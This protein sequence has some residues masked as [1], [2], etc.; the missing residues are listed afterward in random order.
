MSYKIKEVVGIVIFSI[1]NILVAYTITG[2]LGI[3]NII[4]FQ[5]LTTM[6]YVITYEV[7]IWF[8]LSLIESSIY[9]MTQKKCEA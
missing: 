3:Q 8:V 4:L 2:K 5:S 1:L 9:E 7:I 6:T